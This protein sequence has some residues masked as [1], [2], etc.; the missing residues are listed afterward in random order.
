MIPEIQHAYELNRPSEVMGKRPLSSEFFKTWQEEGL[1]PAFH[2]VCDFVRD[3]GHTDNVPVKALGIILGSSLLTFGKL[4]Q[5]VE[6]VRANATDENYTLP[7]RIGLS[8]YAG[9]VGMIMAGHSEANEADE[10]ATYAVT[11]DRDGNPMYLPGEGKMTKKKA[12]Q[13]I[14]NGFY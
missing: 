5:Y 2:G 8:L 11:H 12:E 14:K 7:Q 3:Y 13:A 6:M 4:T 1:V 9:S 10:D